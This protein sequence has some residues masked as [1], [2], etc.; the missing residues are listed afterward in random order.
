LSAI[1]ST[2]VST[3]QLESGPFS[4]SYP[5]LA[6][7]AGFVGGNAS[8]HITRTIML[9][10]LKTLLG[11][12]ASDVGR[13]VYRVGVV[14]DNVLLKATATT[15][16]K[17]FIVLGQLYG[18][19]PSILLFRAL[20]DFWDTDLDAQPLLAVLCAL[21]RD[22]TLHATAEPV[23][24]ASAGA[25]VTTKQLSES[26]ANSFPERFS[27]H[28]LRSIGANAASSWQQAG[29]LCGRLT[30]IRQR[31]NSRPVVVAYALLL[32][33]LCGR[34]G[35]G[36]FET[37]WARVLDAPVGELRAQAA[38]ASQQGWLEYRHSG[39]ITE[40][41]FRHL[42]RDWHPGEAM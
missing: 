36:L 42:L 35:E 26:V 20:R 3:D 15:R 32:G 38:I 13:N 7:S 21:A 5:V 6:R 18:L 4:S 28:S 30:K 10:Q 27:A 34:R 39:G 19:D 29:H 37:R 31:V 23:L 8:P 12:C 16:R 41:T 24:S 22:P 1:G 17:T 33:H 9:S 2:E 14:D 25:T 40:V 11:V